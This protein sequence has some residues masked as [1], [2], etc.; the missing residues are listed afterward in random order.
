M[1]LR[2]IRM[3]GDEVLTKKCREVK[4]ITPR[5]K[6]LIGDMLETMYQS[7]GCGLAAPQVGVLKRLVVVD[8]G[9]GPIIL[10]NPVIIAS[11]GEQVGNEA[12]LS[13]PGKSGQVSRPNYVKIRAYDEN[14]KV[15]EVEGEELLARAFCHELD[16]L[17][18]NL[19]MNRVIGELEDV[20][21][22]EDEEE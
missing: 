5:I 12:C 13:L 17:D 3:V 18:G 8:V 21:Y 16:H 4:Q 10:L 15:F 22:D 6:E 20:V 1:A 7:N 14:L 19:Y 11:L 9:D 2:T